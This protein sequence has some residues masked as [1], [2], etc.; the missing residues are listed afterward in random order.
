MTLTVF[1]NSTL[2]TPMLN[3]EMTGG[4]ST[5]DYLQ[6]EYPTVEGMWINGLTAITVKNTMQHYL[7]ERFRRNFVLLNIGSVECYSHPAKNI[8]YWMCQYLQFYGADPLFQ[9][10]AFPKM[11]QAAKDLNESNSKFHRILDRNEFETILYSVL[12]LLEGFSV[13]VIGMNKPNCNNKRIEPH[14]MTQAEEYKQ[15]IEDCCSQFSNI[16]YIDSWNKYQGYVV[17]TTHLTPEGH[18]KIFE[19]IQSLIE[20]GREKYEG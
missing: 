12:A 8:L 16:D 18:M 4:K 1:A 15:A 3:E 11:Y 13:I 20:K 9:T 7:R 17:D 2:Y 5:F 10:Y 6:E 19:E 14:W